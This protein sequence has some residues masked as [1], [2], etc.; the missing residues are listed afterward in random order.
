MPKK[1]APNSS[2]TIWKR[3]DGRYGVALSRPYHD[4]ETGRIKRKRESTTRADWDS[5]HR[6]LVGK[7]KEVI[8]G[9]MESPE[10][11]RLADY[12]AEWLR[13]VVEPGVARNTYLKREYA[14]RHLSAEMGRARLSEV[15][16]RR[17][18]ALYSKLIRRDPPLSYA[19]RREIHIT[20]KMALKQAVVWG[21]VARNVA[22]MAEVPKGHEEK[23]EDVR[24]LTNEQAKRLFESTSGKRWHYY[25][26]AAIRTGL[27]PGEMLGLRW[28]DL[29]LGGDPG[30][31][32]VRRTLDTHSVARFG[33]P[34]SDAGRRTIALHWEA[35]EALSDQREMIEAEGLPRGANDLVFPSTIGTPMSADNLRNRNLGPDL[36]AAELPGLTLHELRHTFASIMLHEWGIAPAIVQEML[37]HRSIT[38]T[39][40]L[41]GHLF[42]GAQQEAIRALR[43]MHTK[44][45]NRDFETA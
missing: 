38:M 2:G 35:Q 5:A 41:Y 19:T 40:G 24:A 26:I 33:P 36:A 9:I 23:S 10:D 28:G 17:I 22:E 15:N 44:P 6:W 43:K 13:D 20:L 7:K 1:R 42:P 31:L 3:P 18:H 29:D 39:M 12:L 11:P 45:E 4:S 8:S 16:P 30:S 32:K 37:G 21:L 25:Y 14:A 27:R 34:K